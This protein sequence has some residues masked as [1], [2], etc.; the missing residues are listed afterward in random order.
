MYSDLKYLS[1]PLPEDLEKLKWFGD[2]AR[3]ERVIDLKL[4]NASLPLALRKRL[5][6]EKEIIRLMPGEYPFTAE[7]ALQRLREVFG[8]F[9]AEELDSLRDQDAVEWAYINGELRFKDNFLS[10]LIKTRAQYALRVRDHHRLTY[11]EHNAALL[12]DA[13][14]KMKN[15]GGMGMR[16]HMKSTMTLR[17]GRENA[18]REATVWLPIPI[19]YAQVKNFKILSLSHP[20]AVVSPEDFPQRTVC[21]HGP[22]DENRPF[23]VEYEYETHM[24][25]IKPDPALVTDSQPTFYTEE[26]APHI[27]F[28]PYL[29]A[30]AAEITSGEKNPLIAARKIYDF[31][32]TRVMYSYMRAYMT[33]PMVPE[34]CATSLKGDCGVQALLFITLCRICGIPAR[35]QAGLYV[36]P[37]DVGSHDW[38]QFY[39]AP[40]G[41]LFADPSFGGSAWRAGAKERW[42]FYF[43]NLDPYRMPANSEYQH[44]FFIPAR[45]LRHDPYDNQQGEAEYQE[46]PVPSAERETEHDLLHY[47]EI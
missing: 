22:A 46:G 4:A 13:V 24:R 35:W 3:M 32:T 44:D 17:P 47:K 5:E 37:L 9:T 20:N 6:L 18:G 14:A 7:E 29:K 38:T 36:E 45:F 16:F 25:Y 31:I 1:V 41:W 10:N 23:S 42:D 33:M 40:Y 39:V 12:T 30:L 21:F 19:E 27:R 8:D 15:Q 11:A 2:F 34:Y 43:G 26:Y 28:T